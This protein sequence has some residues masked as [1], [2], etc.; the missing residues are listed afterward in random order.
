MEQKQTVKQGIV[1]RK[2]C[3]ILLLCL[4]PCTVP[5]LLSQEINLEDGLILLLPMNGNAT[6]ESLMNVPTNIEGPQ[7]TNDR[8]NKEKQAYLF[9]GIDDKINLNNN[10][11]LITSDQFTICMWA[12]INGR[13]ETL[14][15]PNNLLFEQSNRTTG[16]K[17]SIQ[18]SSDRIVNTVFTLKSSNGTEFESLEADYP[19]DLEWHHFAASFDVE[20][21]MH[22]YIDGVLKSSK[23][24]TG[25]GNFHNGV[26]SVNIGSHPP[27]PII[28]GAF[29]GVIDDVYIYNRALNLCEIETLYSG[30]L[31]QER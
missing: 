29:N 30:Q 28:T 12:K 13:S 19:G 1:H 20:R 27:D 3:L 18:F 2:T 10:Q 23:K 31:L 21:T 22:I 7:L 8:D 25:S 26:N 6:D 11:P 4:L 24:F 5:I 15:I 14:P 16:S 9:D 17:E